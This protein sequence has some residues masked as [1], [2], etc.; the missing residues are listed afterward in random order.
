LKEE[1]EMMG[2]MQRYPPDG[3]VGDRLLAC[4]KYW[5]DEGVE[6]E[7]A[8]PRGAEIRE[9]E[10]VNGDWCWGVYCGVGKLFPANHVVKV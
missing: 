7:L 6:D 10:D 1:E 5:P 9:A 2:R 3:G 4:W 8:F